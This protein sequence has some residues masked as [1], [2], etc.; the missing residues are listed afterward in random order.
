MAV[1]YPKKVTVNFSVS[2]AVPG[3][4]GILKAEVDGR[5]PEDGGKNLTTSFVPGDNVW[6]LVYTGPG[7]TV[8]DS[9]TSFG[10]FPCSGSGGSEVVKQE[11]I[12]TFQAP[13]G[14]TQTLSYPAS[15]INLKWLGNTMSY[16]FDADTCT[17]TAKSTKSRDI[18][19]AKVTYTSHAMAVQLTGTKIV[20]EF[21]YEIAVLLIGDY[22]PIGYAP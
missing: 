16:T 15:S 14:L 1:V 11:E 7:V 20:G 2:F 3:L 8:I 12:M 19:V 22:T 17:I 13:D 6:C 18:A 9:I 4:D 5:T 10:N 21:E